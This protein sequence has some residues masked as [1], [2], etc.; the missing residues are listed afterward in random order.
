MHLAEGAPHYGILILGEGLTEDDIG[1]LP[2]ESRL[3]Q[4]WTVKPTSSASRPL[5]LCVR[6]APFRHRREGQP[7]LL[8]LA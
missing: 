1:R 3:E 5:P 4:I 8:I 2:R 7:A 6:I